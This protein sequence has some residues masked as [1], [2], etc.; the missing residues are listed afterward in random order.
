MILSA[1]ATVRLI[2][3]SDHPTGFWAEEVA[4]SHRVLSEA[5]FEVDIAT[6]GGARPTVDPAS[7]DE[8]GGVAEAD[9]ADFR[10]YLD[11]IEDSLAAPLPVAK[12]S[13]D[14]YDA[15]Y[16]PG[17]HAPMTDLAIDAEVGRLLADAAARDLP[18]AA[19]CHGLA[20]LL[21]ATRPDG[22][23]AFAGKRLT[24]FSDEEE[25]QGGLGEATPYFVEARLRRL[26]ALPEPG[27]PWSSTVVVDGT[28]ITGQNS[29][30]SVETA[31]RLLAMLGDER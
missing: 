30:S 20:A 26:G 15:V 5:G 6:P 25:L 14:D 21:S 9:A 24:S 3:G 23:F 11:S 29:Q 18:I 19:L 4:A 28:L 17:G 31:Q 10:R 1:A 13:L 2:D 12:V 27:P 7:L 22:T 16:I 8:R